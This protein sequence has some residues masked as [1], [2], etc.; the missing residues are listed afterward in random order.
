HAE[1]DYMTGGVN[2][3]RNRLR[4]AR[5]SDIDHPSGRSPDKRVRRLLICQIRPADDLAAI[6]NPGG[7]TVAAEGA[8]SLHA[9]GAIPNEGLYVLRLSHS[10]D[11]ECDPSDDEELECFHCGFVWFT[12]F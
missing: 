1:A 11:Y 8:E 7:I 10:C 9:I 6:V 2:R 12:F 3:L 4:A 5:R